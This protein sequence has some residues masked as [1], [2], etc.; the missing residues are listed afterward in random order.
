MRVDMTVHL[1]YMTLDCRDSARLA[2]FWS[3][4]LGWRL[5]ADEEWGAVLEP[6]D[7]GL[8][9]LYLQ[10]V[11]EPKAGKNRLHLDLWVDDLEAERERLLELGARE[12]SRSH[13]E[14]GRPFSIMGDPEDN[15]FCVVARPS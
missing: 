8:P 13:S 2:R 12:Q 10:P 1:R 5:D 11:P 4:A 6:P 14:D 3:A 15:E 7:G 9:G